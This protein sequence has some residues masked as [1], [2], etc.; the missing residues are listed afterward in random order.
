MVYKIG[1]TKY[2]NTKLI[3]NEGN[4]LDLGVFWLVPRLYSRR[5]LLL[6]RQ[7]SMEMPC[8]C[9]LVSFKAQ[10]RKILGTS[11]INHSASVLSIAPT[12]A[13]YLSGEKPIQISSLART[14]MWL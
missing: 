6:F 4:A 3:C 8:Q 11:S 13:H 10:E 9:Q 14:F 2:G 7:R 1:R 12:I 5:R